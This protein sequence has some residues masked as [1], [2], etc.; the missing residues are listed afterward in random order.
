[1]ALISVD[2]QQPGKKVYNRG[3]QSKLNQR[4][5]GGHKS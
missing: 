4:K 3:K 5:P 1:M 2:N